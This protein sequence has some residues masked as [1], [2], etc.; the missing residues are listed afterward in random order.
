MVMFAHRAVQTP[1]A[2]AFTDMAR[3]IGKAYSE[4]T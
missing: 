3:I 4:S 1:T 2:K